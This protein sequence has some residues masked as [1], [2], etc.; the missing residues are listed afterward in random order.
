VYSLQAAAGYFGNGHDVENEGWVEVPD[1]FGSIDN[2][3]FVSQVVGRSMEPTIPDTSY[4]VF[5]RIPAGS[6]QG[7][8]VL[9]EHHSIDDVETGG[10]YTVKRYESRKQE[11]DGEVA[12]T[13]ELRPLNP[14]FEPIVLESGDDAQVQVIAEFVAVLRKTAE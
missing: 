14:E 9:A 13:V 1:D 10:S 4:C 5:R 11:S 7:K 3:M 12:G 8:I 6:R 2:S